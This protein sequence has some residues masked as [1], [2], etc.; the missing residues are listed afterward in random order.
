MSIKSEYEKRIEAYVDSNPGSSTGRSS[1]LVVEGRVV[2]L[3]IYRLPIKCLVF[4]IENGRFAVDLYTLEKDLGRKVNTREVGDANKVRQILLDKSPNDTKLLRDDLKKQG[5]VEPGVITAAGVVIN[6]NRRMAILME[7]FEQ[8]S[9]D[10]FAYL[11]AVILPRNINDAEIYKIEARL[12]YAKDFKVG[13]G[14]V[15]ELL[16]IKEGINKGMSK[17]E[18]A[19]LLGRDENYIE[20]HLEQ[21]KLL[22]AYSNY[23]WKKVNYKKIEDEQITEPITDVQKNLRKFKNEGRRLSEIKKLLEIQ[24]DYIRCGAKYRDIRDFG[25]AASLR[26]GAQ[27]YYKAHSSLKSGKISEESF[28]EMVDDANETIKIKKEDKKPI[29]LALRALEIVRNMEN[30]QFKINS[31]AGKYLKEISEIITKLLKKRN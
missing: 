24:F 2:D 7:L 25:K 9:D 21:L 27:L 10:K 14:A 15:N 31:E 4:N 26:G 17:K 18:L 8:T 11:E 22:E 30:K 20:E 19:A 29:E 28:K 16:K 13:F 1:R 12:Q 3:P 5:Q 6:A 23:T